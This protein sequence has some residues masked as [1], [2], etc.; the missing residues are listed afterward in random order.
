MGGEIRVTSEPGKGSTFRVKMLLSEVTNPTRDRARS[1][2]PIYGY[3]GPRRTI[4][5]VDDDPTHRDL[6]RELLTPLG[7]ILLSAPDGPGC[8][9]LA[10]HCRPDLF[11]LDISMAGMD[12]WKV[13]RDAA[14]QRPS[15]G[16]HRHAVG[17]C[18]G[19]ARRAAGE[20]YHDDYLVKPID[21]PQTAGTRSGKLLQ[22]RMALRG[23]PGAVPRWKPD[24]RLAAAREARRGT[25]P[26]R[27]RSATSAASRPSWTR[28]ATIIPNT[29]DFVSQMRSA[30]RPLRSRSV[31]GDPEELCTAMITEQKKRDIV[32][33]VDDS[34]ETLRLLTDAL[35]GAGMTVL[36][37][38]DGA[39]ALRDR[40]AD[41]AGHHPARR[42]HAGHR[43]VRDLPA[44]EAR[45]R[46]SA[47]VPVIFMTGLTETE[48][49]VH[50]LE[51]GGVDYVTKPIVIEELLAR[52][53]VHLANARLTPER[54]RGAR[55]LRT[56]S[57]RRRSAS[58]RCCGRR[59]RREAAVGDA[60]PAATTIVALP[61][62][63]PA[64]AG[65]AASGQAGPKRQ[66]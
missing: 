42:G 8:L 3:D 30:D 24:D 51:A 32:L 28:S 38:L 7:F 62:P 33:V 34:P 58:A 2:A 47:H 10:Q 19:S 37:A 9:A 15:P 59:R 26:A 21:L 31:H 61:N 12:G 46:R 45:R 39:A 1:E 29:A 63:M 52:I 6:L 22:A 57:A 44:A 40:R 20:P 13:A 55:R 43:R 35:D 4:L 49:V 17:E 56:L 18:D 48:H 64:M 54:A 41:H 36:V 50:G 66:P 53:R 27:R 16:A 11:L 25:D 23:R 65:Q 14:R 60:R 5:V